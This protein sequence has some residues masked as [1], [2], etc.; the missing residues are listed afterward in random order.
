MQPCCCYPLP[1][2][3]RAGPGRFERGGDVYKHFLDGDGY[4]M[5][6]TFKDGKAHFKNRCERVTE[7]LELADVKFVCASRIRLLKRV[8]GD[9]SRLRR[10]AFM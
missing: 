6:V 3:C 1:Y 2:C 7:F 4:I 9:K 8:T 5:R 10:H